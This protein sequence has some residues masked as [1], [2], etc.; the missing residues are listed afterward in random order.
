MVY[1]E[2]A[3]L[4]CRM[5]LWRCSVLGEAP[6]WVHR[7]LSLLDMPGFFRRSQYPVSSYALLDDEALDNDESQLLAQD[8]PNGN[9]I[10]ANY[11][12][13]SDSETSFSLYYLKR[14]RVPRI[15]FAYFKQSRGKTSLDVFLCITCILVILNVSVWLGYHT[16]KYH[17]PVIDKSYRAFGI[18]NHVAW[19]N[20]GAFQAAKKNI[21]SFSHGSRYGRS[22]S[23]EGKGTINPTLV[24]NILHVPYSNLHEAWLFL[25]YFIC[26]ISVQ[27]IVP[28][29]NIS[30]L[31]EVMKFIFDSDVN[32][33]SKDFFSWNYMNMKSLIVIWTREKPFI[34]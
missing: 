34:L 5:N 30:N 18:P 27:I 4:T 6:L 21:T 23:N 9:E 25:K 16:L 26:N 20:Y 2:V 10:P 29:V 32:E 11:I 17:M 14:F 12:S 3:T 19:L 1:S 13:D 15:N 28:N 24:L 31:C 7:Y 8:V 33:V 22:V